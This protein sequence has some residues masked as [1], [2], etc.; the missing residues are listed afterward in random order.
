VRTSAGPI[1]YKGTTSPIPIEPL[2][3]LLLLLL[4]LCYFLFSF[5]S[6]SCLEVRIVPCTLDSSGN[7]VTEITL[8]LQRI[9]MKI[10]VLLQSIKMFFYSSSL[11]RF[12]QQLMAFQIYGWLS[13]TA[14]LHIPIIHLLTEYR[15]LEILNQV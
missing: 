9:V 13:A 12:N 8:R 3:L 11:M 5:Y 1:P 4:L 7:E 10:I 2:L 6:L 14:C 15:N